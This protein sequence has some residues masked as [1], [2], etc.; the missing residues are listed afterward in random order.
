ME[1]PAISGEVTDEGVFQS[2]LDGYS[3]VY[4]ALPNGDTFNR[5]WREK[6]YGG[7]FPVEFAHIGFLTLA[8]AERLRSLM[9]MSSGSVLVLASGLPVFGVD[10]VADYRP[11]LEAA[12]FAIDAYEETPG[13]Q[14]RVY[15]VYQALIDSSDALNA[16]MGEAAAAGV[17]AELM[18][19][20]AVKPYPRRVLAVATAH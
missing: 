13:W 7:E 6:A 4:D 16:E 15:G 12:G 18:L 5:I 19:T 17:L 2:V 20:V 1:D 10:P 8:E 9:S 14:E 3:A 11:V